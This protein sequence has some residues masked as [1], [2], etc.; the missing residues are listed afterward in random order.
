MKFR[1]REEIQKLKNSKPPL[2]KCKCG[3]LVT[4]NKNW[5][6][7]NKYII[8]H[9]KS[10][11][12]KTK[13]KKIQ[14]IK[15]KGPPLCKCGCGK[16]TQ[17]SKKHRKWNSF[18]QCHNSPRSRSFKKKERSLPPLCQCGCG[19]QTNW[20]KNKSKWANYIKD[21]YKSN[22]TKDKHHDW[23]GGV[24]KKT[25]RKYNNQ[26]SVNKLAKK[27]NITIKESAQIYR[28]L[29][30]NGFSSLQKTITK[31]KYNE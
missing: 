7:W 16:I 26:T 18:L 8:G 13:I 9:C 21:H 6:K 25:R 15:D 27:L 19:K 12:M 30:D 14:E 28:E 31:E 3:N 24:S 22:R 17:W 10:N 1:S 23:K 11:W 29:Y 2:C 5:Q 4:W 20:L